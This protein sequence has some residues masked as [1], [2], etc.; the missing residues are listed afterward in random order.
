MT[1]TNRAFAQFRGLKVK[2][3]GAQTGAYSEADSFPSVAICISL[4]GAWEADVLPLNYI[5][6]DAWEG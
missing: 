1:I 4:T 2:V 5:G 3:H 6:D